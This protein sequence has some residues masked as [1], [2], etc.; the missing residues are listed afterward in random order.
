[1][2]L[3]DKNVYGNFYPN[4][5]LQCEFSIRY[6]KAFGTLIIKCFSLF[7]KLPSITYKRFGKIEIVILVP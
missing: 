4:D 5:N 3:N 1:M 2:L 7:A 6:I